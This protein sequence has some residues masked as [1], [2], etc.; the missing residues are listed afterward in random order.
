[1][2][3]PS[4]SEGGFLQQVRLSVRGNASCTQLSIPQW[5]FGVDYEYILIN[6]SEVPNFDRGIILTPKLG[7]QM[8]VGL[9]N[10]RLMA[11]HS[12]VRRFNRSDRSY[13]A[14][15]SA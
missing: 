13:M 1:M 14:L 7:M 11:A 2:R 4:K 9:F 8:E 6:Y 15:E 10:I 12:Y 3:A 5:R